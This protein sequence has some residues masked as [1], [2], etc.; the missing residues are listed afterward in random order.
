MNGSRKEMIKNVN[1]NIG[2][3]SVLEVLKCMMIGI[4]EEQKC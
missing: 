2:Y 3:S 1:G 4:K